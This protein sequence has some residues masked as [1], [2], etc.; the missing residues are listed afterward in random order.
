LPQDI[1]QR[2]AEVR[3]LIILPPVADV[4]NFNAF[5]AAFWLIESTA[6]LGAA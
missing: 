6:V 1:E 5:A 3:F 4:V 2:A